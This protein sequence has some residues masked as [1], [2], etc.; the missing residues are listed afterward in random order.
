MSGYPGAPP[1]GYPGAP[2]AGYPGA[3]Q[4]GYPGAPPAQ[5]GYPGAPPAQGG[6]PGAPP[7]NGGY[8]GAPPAQGGYPGAPPAQGGYPGAPPAQG[9]YP[10]GPPAQGGYPGNPPQQQVDPQVAEWFGAVDTDRSGQIDAKELQ[11]ALMNGNMSKF[12]EEACMMMIDLY[13][14]DKTGQINVNEFGALFKFINQW[15]AAFEALDHDKSGT[16]NEQAFAQSL[17]QS[18][19]RFSPGFISS[20]VVKYSPR[21][22]RVTLDN[23]I[24]A[25]VQI[26]R[27]TDS[28]RTRDTQMNGTANMAYEDFVGLAMGA[29]K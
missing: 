17:G 2:P 24:V 23:F 8:P 5:G 29:H 9:G 15:K 12:S 16:I 22:R 28:F 13:D 25:N 26:R 21:D 11:G 10:G 3:P 7:A 19:F 1:A 20:L 27:L 4:G 18:G 6:Y 14:S